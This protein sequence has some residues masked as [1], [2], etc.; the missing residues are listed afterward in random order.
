MFLPRHFF[1]LLYTKLKKTDVIQINQESFF[2][3]KDLIQPNRFHISKMN[4]FLP[5][6][7]IFYKNFVL[8]NLFLMVSAIKECIIISKKWKRLS[9]RKPFS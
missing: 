3:E 6:S 8:E 7:A 5:N 4:K 9:C 1:L 2:Q